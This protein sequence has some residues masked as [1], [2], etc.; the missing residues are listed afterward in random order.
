MRLFPH[1][2]LAVLGWLFTL[3]V[4]LHNMEEALYLPTWSSHGSKWRMP[5]E[6]RIFRLA[7]VIFSA[8]LVILTTIASFS[9]SQS[10]AAYLMSGY[11]LAMLLNVL[12]PH[13]LATLF[14]RSYMPGTVT[15]VLLNLP[16]GLLYLHRALSEHNIEPR[17]FFWAGPATVA[18]IVAAI[19]ALFA[20][21]RKFHSMPPER[22]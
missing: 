17:T 5:V 4:L 10:I 14:T 2:P 15:A 22:G 18:A 13:L 20:L 16:L 3:G 19:P 21:A 9:H 11:V 8:L 7:A 12:A 6:A 1:L